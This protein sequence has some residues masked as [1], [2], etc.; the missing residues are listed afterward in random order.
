MRTE[1]TD[2]E[3]PSS[4]LEAEINEIL[5]RSVRPPTIRDRLRAFL[6]QVRW[7]LAGRSLPIGHLWSRLGESAFLVSA[8][9]VALV[10]YF[11]R[12]ASPMVARVLAIIAAA[13]VFLP[14]IFSF[15]GPRPPAAKRW[16]G[17]VM[18]DEPPPQRPQWLDRMFRR[19]PRRD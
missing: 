6:T 3:R 19:P 1:P 18:F 16:R 10:A 15:T 13:L 11:L 9:V 7:R 12:D 5:A 2:A 14:I 17:R 8:I 4:R